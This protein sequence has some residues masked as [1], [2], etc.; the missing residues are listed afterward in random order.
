M[1]INVTDTT[2]TPAV[3]FGRRFRRIQ[4]DIAAWLLD[5]V[6]YSRVPASVRADLD[7]EIIDLAEK[8]VLGIE[9]KV[10]EEISLFWTKGLDVKA[11]LPGTLRTTAFDAVS[12]FQKAFSADPVNCLAAHS[13]KCSTFAVLWSA[14]NKQ[15]AE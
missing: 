12:K 13:E 15:V 6:D 10:Q 2:V 7:D 8:V 4:D 5:Q 11:L 1:D 9:S 3:T 14:V